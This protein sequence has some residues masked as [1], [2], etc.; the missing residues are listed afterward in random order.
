M[1]STIIIGS[2]IACGCYKKT[3]KAL[4][5]IIKELIKRCSSPARIDDFCTIVFSKSNCSNN[6]SRGKRRFKSHN[7][8]LWGN[9]YN[10]MIVI[11][12][13][14]DSPS[15]MGPMSVTSRKWICVIVFKIISY[16]TSS[17]KNSSIIDTLITIPH[18]S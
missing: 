11:L 9:S 3:R 15:H 13:S 16:E 12:D 18:I 7:F 14:S 8:C 17:Q 1:S 2:R 6:F 10:S 5:C 4:Y